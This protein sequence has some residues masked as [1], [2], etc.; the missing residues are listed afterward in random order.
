MSLQKTDIFQQH[1]TL[2]IPTL[3]QRKTLLNAMLS[4]FHLP[5]EVVDDLVAQ[6]SL[7]TSGYVAR[8]LAMVCRNAKLKSLRRLPTTEESL[9]HGLSQLKLDPT[10]PRQPTITWEDLAYAL[11]IHKPSQQMEVETLLPKRQWDEIGG[12]ETMK[13][14]IRQATVIPLLQPELF[15]RLG[16]PAPSGLLLYGPSGCGKTALVQALATEAMMNV[17]AI[18]GPQIYSKYLGD[19]ERSIRRLFATAKRIAPCLIVIDEMDA[20]A[21]RRGWNGGGEGGVNERVLSTLLNEMDGV[22]GRQGVLVIGCTNRPHQIDDAILRPGRL[23]Q[24]LYVGMPDEQDR[25][26]I[27]E[28]IKRHLKADDD[29]NTQDLAKHTTHCTGADLQLLFREAATVALRENTKIP[30]IAQRHLN[31]VLPSICT[32]ASQRETSLQL[33]EQFQAKHRI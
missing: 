20:I 3:Q 23:D 26:Q 8:D 32:R 6:T 16:V 9:I 1:F 7:R 22:E 15:Q 31:H 10:N 24:L 2:G 28:A 33:F 30:A 13:R 12:Y 17:I 27:M 18:N 14:R 29:V 4:D 25:Q 21:C 11:E 5:N 19:T